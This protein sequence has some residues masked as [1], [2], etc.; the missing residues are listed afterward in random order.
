MSHVSSDIFMRSGSGYLTFDDA[1]SMHKGTRYAIMDAEAQCP[2][3]YKLSKSETSLQNCERHQD[4]PLCQSP[5]AEGS[6]DN[7]FDPVGT[8][9]N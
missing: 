2:V 4:V 6:L 9:V 7:I 8:C 5:L 3:D 1:A